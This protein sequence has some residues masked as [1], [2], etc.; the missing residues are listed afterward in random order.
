MAEMEQ[1]GALPSFPLSRR[2]TGGWNSRGQCSPMREAPA[3]GPQD[4]L[5]PTHGPSLLGWPQANHLKA[6]EPFF[7]FC[8][9]KEIKYDCMSCF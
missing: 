8:N 1:G 2:V 7:L 9:I 3:L 6:S 4:R 5:N